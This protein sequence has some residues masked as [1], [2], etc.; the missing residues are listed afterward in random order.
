MTSKCARLQQGHGSEV[1]LSSQTSELSIIFW[2]LAED[3][4]IRH[5]DTLTSS[6]DTG[7]H[8]ARSDQITG[9]II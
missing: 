9:I 4:N 6:T 5:E 8:E 2:G 7:L 3:A 1:V